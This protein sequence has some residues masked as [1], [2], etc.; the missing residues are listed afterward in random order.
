MSAQYFVG[1]HSPA[2]SSDVFTVRSCIGVD[3]I[4]RALTALAAQQRV[5]VESLILTHITGW[6][7]SLRRADTAS[8]H[9]VTQS[10]TALTRCGREKRIL[11][12]PIHV[13]ISY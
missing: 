2:L 13:H 1:S 10:A 5:V 3:A 6:F 11:S 8:R 4:W 7:D 9:L 12:G